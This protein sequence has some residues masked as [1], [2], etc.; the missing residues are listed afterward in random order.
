[1]LEKKDWENAKKSSEDQIKQ[2][3][4]NLIVGNNLLA[5]ANTELSKF[6]EEE[7]KEEE[8]DPMPEEVKEMVK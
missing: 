5:L 6:P 3:E 1:M 4:I 2:A 8:D 7:K